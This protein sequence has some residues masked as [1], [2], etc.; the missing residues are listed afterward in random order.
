MKSYWPIVFGLICLAQIV[1]ITWTIY[2]PGLSLLT[3]DITVALQLIVYGLSATLPIFTG[4][5]LTNNFPDKMIT[6]KQKRNFNIITSVNLLLIPFMVSFALSGYKQIPTLT[7]IAETRFT[8]Q[9][10][11]SALELTLSVLVLTVHLVILFGLYF[12]RDF[13]NSNARD[14][15]SAKSSANPNS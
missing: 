12:L 6:G 7:E 1:L 2:Y 14:K 5:V 9:Q 10:F 8:S 3:G 15:E 11:F 13:I 4:S